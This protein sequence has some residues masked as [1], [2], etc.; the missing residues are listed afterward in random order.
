MYANTEYVKE[1][2]IGEWKSLCKNFST[3]T[4]IRYNVKVYLEV[5]GNMWEKKRA[6]NGP[7]K[8]YSLANGSDINKQERY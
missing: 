7:K 1:S 3:N 8:N 4:I 6:T 5:V 2:L